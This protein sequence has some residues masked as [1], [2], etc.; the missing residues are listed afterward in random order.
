MFIFFLFYT[1]SLNDDVLLKYGELPHVLPLA[2]H[3]ENCYPG[4]IEGLSLVSLFSV[5][6]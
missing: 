3:L 6:F 5:A 4:W 2:V 1:I